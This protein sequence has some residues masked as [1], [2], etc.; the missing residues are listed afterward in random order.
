MNVC[1]KPFQ[2]SAYKPPYSHWQMSFFVIS[3]HFFN[4]GAVLEKG[5]PLSFLGFYMANF[6]CSDRD[7]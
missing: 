4:T 5:L 3:A 7:T 1:E 2:F 6:A